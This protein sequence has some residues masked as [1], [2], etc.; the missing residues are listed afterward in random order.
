MREETEQKMLSKLLFIIL[1][2]TISLS[3]CNRLTKNDKNK[4]QEKHEKKH[5][6]K[7]EIIGKDDSHG[8]DERENVIKEVVKK[9]VESLGG[10]NPF[11]HDENHLV[12]E[13]TVKISKDI[14]GAV[15]F[16]ENNSFLSKYAPALCNLKLCSKKLKVSGQIVG[17]TPGK[18]GLHIHE[19]GDLSD[20]CDSIGQHFNPGNNKHG[21][22]GHPKYKRHI[23][24]LGNIV[25]DNE[26]IA[27]F[28]FSIE[29]TSIVEGD[30]AIVGRALAIHSEPDDLGRGN[31]QFSKING[32]SGSAIACGVIG[33]GPKV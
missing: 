5:H 28:S 12:A 25:A 6:K 27:K 29:D 2:L 23:G 30:T 9:S 11:K 24:D 22:P 15:E 13:L 31:N 16:E 17:L 33:F 32:N 8:E 3:H 20:G 7:D 18:H 4:D 21:G 26:G 14:K 1:L 19:Y 10:Q